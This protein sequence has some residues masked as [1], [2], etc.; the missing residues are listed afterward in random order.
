[1]EEKAINLGVKIPYMSFDDPMFRFIL[2]ALVGAVVVGYLI[3]NK[4]QSAGN[5]N[6]KSSGKSRGGG[7]GGNRNNKGG[8]NRGGGN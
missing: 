5:G 2:I 8:G 3:M 6:K 1:L 7:G 4:G